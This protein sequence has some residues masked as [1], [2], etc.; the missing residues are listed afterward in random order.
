MNMLPRQQIY[1]ATGVPVRSFRERSGG[2]IQYCQFTF[3]ELVALRLIQ[4][5]IVIV[6]GAVL[7]P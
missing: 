5:I 6:G 2:N 1:D 7:S 4:H 3:P